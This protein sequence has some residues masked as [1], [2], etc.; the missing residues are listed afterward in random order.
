MVNTDRAIFTACIRTTSAVIIRHQS[1][2]IKHQLIWYYNGIVVV[3]WGI[4]LGYSHYSGGI[5]GC[6]DGSIMVQT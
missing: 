3:Q 1:I 5:V 6:N 4:D 2:N